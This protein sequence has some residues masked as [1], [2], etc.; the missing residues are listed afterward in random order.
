MFVQR[1]AHSFINNF[2]C[3]KHKYCIISA[4]IS[5][6]SLITS[7]HL[8][9]KMNGTHYSTGINLKDAENKSL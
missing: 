9:F 8:I 5:C 1:S 4:V 6:L 2:D 7:F 3:F